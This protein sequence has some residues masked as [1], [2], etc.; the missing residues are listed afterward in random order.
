MFLYYRLGIFS[1]NRNLW[2]VSNIGIFNPR[3][4]K[5]Y[6]LNINDIPEDVLNTLDEIFLVKNWSIKL[7]LRL[8]LYYIYKEKEVTYDNYR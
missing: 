6:V 2:N 7:W 4:N 3:L 1:N 8:M 5:Y